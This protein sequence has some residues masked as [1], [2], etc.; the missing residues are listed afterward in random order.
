MNKTLLSFLVTL[1]VLFI[2]TRVFKILDF[3]TFW[4]TLIISSLV[5]S[6]FFLKSKFKEI[7]K[8]VCFALVSI[9]MVL[10]ILIIVLSGTLI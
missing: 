10:I 1:I 9:I 4:I 2:L 6:I 5:T 3:P 8:G 7:A